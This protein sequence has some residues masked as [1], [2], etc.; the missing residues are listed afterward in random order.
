MFKWIRTILV[1]ILITIKSFAVEVLSISDNELEHINQLR[2]TSP[3]Q[4]VRQ[5]LNEERDFSYAQN[6]ALTLLLEIVSDLIGSDELEKGSL[7][8]QARKRAE[9][10]AYLMMALNEILKDFNPSTGQVSWSCKYNK[11]SFIIDATKELL[12][13]DC[14]S[15]VDGK[16]PKAF[17]MSSDFPRVIGGRKN[18]DIRGQIQDL[19]LKGAL[20]TLLVA[21]KDED[22]TLADLNF[23][24][25]QLL[26]ERNPILH[27]TP[28]PVEFSDE[29]KKAIC[30]KGFTYCYQDSDSPKQGELAFVHGGYAF[31]GQRD[32]AR[33]Y[34]NSPKGKTFGPE[35]CSS[36]ISK[37]INCKKEIS[38]F[39]L[40]FLYNIAFGGFVDENWK[41]SSEHVALLEVLEPIQIASI[42]DIKPGYIIAS[43]SFDLGVD[44]DMNLTKGS[45]GHVALIIDVDVSNQFLYVIEYSRNLPEFEGFG[46]RKTNLLDTKKTKVMYFRTK[47]A[48][49]SLLK[50]EL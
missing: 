33:Y 24:S 43:R 1:L 28:L 6:T 10:D 23:P 8:S 21:A 39:D 45:S 18:V 11:L 40:L 3:S 13:K 42:E 44:P 4:L 19:G 5:A 22:S 12:E 38:T 27:T 26:V 7:C 48:D 25:S 14:S 47:L 29:Q 37:L 46:I 16:F 20:L 17:P 9:E 30:E 36:W 2:I 50:Q 41:K 32:D 49:K 15:L 34:K 35:D 31:G